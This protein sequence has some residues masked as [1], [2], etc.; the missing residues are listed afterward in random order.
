MS[1]PSIQT[2]SLI[3]QTSSHPQPPGWLGLRDQQVD[4]EKL[5]QQ[6]VADPLG[7]KSKVTLSEVDG[8][9][10]DEIQEVLEFNKIFV[11]TENYQEILQGQEIPVGCKININ[12]SNGKKMAKLDE[13]YIKPTSLRNFP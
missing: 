6:T 10:V 7:E 12:V 1:P 5:I 2:S 4:D 9:L 3:P 11:Q 8:E 13:D